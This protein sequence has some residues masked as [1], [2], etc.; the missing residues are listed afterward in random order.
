[1]KLFFDVLLYID[2]LVLFLLLI[3][4]LIRFPVR[5]EKIDL[6]RNRKNK[7]LERYM[8]N[9]FLRLEIILILK[10]LI[11]FFIALLAFFL[12]RTPKKFENPGFV[13]FIPVLLLLIGTGIGGV[14]LGEYFSRVARKNNI[15]QKTNSFSTGYVR[16][17]SQ[18]GIGV[19]I[20][21]YF[22]LVVFFTLTNLFFVI[23][24][25]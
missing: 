12:G 23:G 16:S 24:L 4:E 11:A 1:M 5:V 14:L 13:F 6:Q 21:F 8:E 9:S 2:C 20:S 15:F 3:K 18:F 25:I 17:R 19:I 22:F 10:F 7:P